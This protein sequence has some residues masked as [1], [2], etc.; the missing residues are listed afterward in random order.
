MANLK[1]ITELP[2]AASAEGLNL[3]VNDNGSAKQIA[4]SAV[5]AQADWA[6]TNENSPAYV[7]N[8]PH[9]ELVYEWNFEASENPD[10]CVWEIMENVNDDLIWLTTLSEDTGWE[11]EV[12]Q[13]GFYEFH[14]DENEMW[15]S[16]VDPNIST[17]SCSI[18]R[19]FNITYQDNVVLE[20]YNCGW[21][22][23][24]LNDWDLE[25]FENEHVVD[26]YNKVHF[27]SDWNITE[28]SS[29]GHFNI[30]V[31]GGGP[32]KSIKIYKITR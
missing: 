1:S 31:N 28:I 3:I 23:D 29:G 27:D 15:V 25:Y 26:V 6:E 11:I 21:C 17:T 12:S 18:D 2:V 7:K 4:A 8:K 20:V 22:Q 24:Y 13:Y 16:I 30:H 9:K 10:D 19:G 32:L 14:D 5:G